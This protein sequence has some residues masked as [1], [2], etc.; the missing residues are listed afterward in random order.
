MGTCIRRTVKLLA[1]GLVFTGSFL[2]FMVRPLV[3]VP[4]KEK[5]LLRANSERIKTDVELLAS[6]LGARNGQDAAQLEKI[7]DAILQ[8]F[9]A[10][11]ARVSLQTFLIQNVGF[12]N[13]ISQYGFNDAAG[14]IIV[15]AHYDTAQGTPGADDNAS[16]VAALLELGRLFIERPPPLKVLLVAY[17]PEEGEFFNTSN[18]GSYVHAA[19]L[20][21]NKE[22]V[23]LMISLES[24]GYFTDLA[25]S[26]RYPLEP[27]SWLYPST[28]NF[29]AIVGN[30]T[31]SP[32]TYT[33]KRAFAQSTTLA[34]HSINAP[35]RIAGISNSDHASFWKTGFDA[36]MITDTAMFRNPN[37]HTPSDLPNTL[38]YD[39]I[40]EVVDG[41]FAYVSAQGPE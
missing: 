19:H 28:G 22:P 12:H 21:L 33:L 41:V 13:V 8:S 23:R 36:V 20:R 32:A 16:G 14:T 26:Q 24:V 2:L 5:D 3:F 6:G 17:A 34:A 10:S 1:L 15:G 31:L 7:S 30:P 35:D 4:L 11:N 40:G 37:Y 25:E 27:L 18:M 38:N 9:K 39:K 29:I